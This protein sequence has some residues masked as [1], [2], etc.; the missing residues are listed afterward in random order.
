MCAGAD[1]LSGMNAVDSFSSR[2]KR[3]S[4][5]WS[6]SLGSVLLPVH[7]SHSL[8]LLFFTMNNTDFV[9]ELFPDSKFKDKFSP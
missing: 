9:L 6:L 8:K 5:E 1:S 2:C 4:S 3:N 7:S